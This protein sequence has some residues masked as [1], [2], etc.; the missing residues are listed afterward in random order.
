MTDQLLSEVRGNAGIITLNR[1]KAINALTHEMV[2]EM[3]KVLDGWHDD[4]AVKL[5]IVRG[6]GER[7]LCAGGDVAALYDDALADGTAGAEFWADEYGLNLMI[8]DY[9]KPYVA[10]MNGLVL[11]G[12]V[13]ISAHGSHRIVTDSTKLG[14]P[15]VGIGFAPDVGG[16]WLLAHAPDNLGFHYGLTGA[17]EGGAQAIEA[18]L[19]DYFVPDELIE[20]LVADLC[21][22]GVVGDI[23]KHAVQPARGFGP[24]R[25]EMA[26]VYDAESVEEILANLDASQAEWASDAAKRIRRNCPLALKVTFASISGAREKT[27]AEAL[28][29]EFRISCNMQRGTEFVEGVRAQLI[30]KDRNPQWNP[31]SLGEVEPEEMARMLGPVDDPRV[32]DIEL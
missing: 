1:E 15:E 22:S 13:G 14:M 32:E 19:A 18:G 24:D 7:G 3:T 10:I 8:S 23:E 29:Q 27:L 21:A 26:R 9:P 28:Q 11:G 30:D 25:V 16:S 17:H 20:T 31:S 5:V 6:A 12:G 2:L 4:P